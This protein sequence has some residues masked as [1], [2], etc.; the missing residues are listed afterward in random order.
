MRDCSVK[1]QYNLYRVRQVM[2]LCTRATTLF[3]SVGTSRTS[4]SSLHLITIPLCS[5]KW[6]NCANVCAYK[7]AHVL[8]APP[9]ARYVFL[10]RKQH[11]DCP[12]DCPYNIDHLDHP[13]PPPPPMDPVMTRLMEQVLSLIGFCFFCYHFFYAPPP[14]CGVP[15]FQSEINLSPTAADGRSCSGGAL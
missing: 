13:P 11:K 8:C 9:R 14:E 10:N 6:I 7:R 5:L 2:G 12:A 3:T 15:C 4:T 1:W